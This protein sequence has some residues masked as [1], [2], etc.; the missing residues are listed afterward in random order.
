MARSQNACPTRDRI[1]NAAD[2]LFAERGFGRTSLRA[3]TREAGVNLAAVNYHFGSKLE[4]L[5]G[6]LSRHVEA[7][8]GERLLRLQELE[9]DP[10][11][12]SIESV[13]GALY[14]PTFEFT[15]ASAENARE[16]QGMMALLFREPPELVRP[17]VDALFRMVT[18]RFVAVLARLLPELPRDLLELRYHLGIGAMIHLLA[19][20]GPESPARDPHEYANQLVS[21]VAAALRGP[22]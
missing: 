15:R 8:N 2:R 12:L 5:H 3:L 14:R 11:S 6:A 13:L 9:A 16:I 7:I 20:R 21:F 10:R 4:L 18:E 22:Q 1:L 17:L 19:D